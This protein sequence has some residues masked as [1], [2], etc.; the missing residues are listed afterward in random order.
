[1][2]LNKIRSKNE[3]EDLLLS[4]TKNCKTNI[5]QTH[6][7]PEETLE[8][9][10]IKPRE[11]CHFNPPNQVKEDWM[12]ALVDLEVYNS[13]SNITEENNNFQLYTDPLDV[14]FSFTEMKD[15]IADLLDIS[16][17]TPGDPE[18][19]TRGPEIFKA[20]RE[21][22]IK[23]GH[24]HGYYFL[25]MNYTQSSLRDFESYVRISTGLKE[26]DIQLK[27]K[28]YNS[29]FN[30]YQMF[31]GIYTFKDISEVLSR[32]FEKDFEIRGEIQP[33]TE[34][35]KADSIINECDNI[36]MK[37]KLIVNYGINALTV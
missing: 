13:M 9:E 6:K 26:D 35:D 5:E 22:S 33:N 28:Q 12:L 15:K 29:K 3:T 25:I 8:F 23:E 36:T 1:M 16:H 37:T 4:V 21:L 17:I 14:D 24:T 7:K 30:P 11:T 18:H 10:M 2:N 31:P 19:K 34:Y 27:L 32:V 20:Y